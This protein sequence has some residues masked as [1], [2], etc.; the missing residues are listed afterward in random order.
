MIENTLVPLVYLAIVAVMAI[1]IYA[2]NRGQ[3]S[4]LTAICEVR[5]TLEQLLAGNRTIEATL[6][7]HRR[8]LYD[9]TQANPH[10][11]QRPPK[12]CPVNP[13]KT[14]QNQWPDRTDPA[15]RQ[16]IGLEQLPPGGNRVRPTQRGGLDCFNGANSS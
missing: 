14:S 5:R 2:M 7:Q 6:E 15:V 1:L 16:G 4:A 9:A 11:S 3:V 13:T 8:V 10:C 12:T